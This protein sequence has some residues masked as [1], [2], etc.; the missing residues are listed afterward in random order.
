MLDMLE[1]KPTRPCDEN[2]MTNEET[3]PALRTHAGTCEGELE[4]RKE[5]YKHGLA[6]AKNGDYRIYVP[7]VR[8]NDEPGQNPTDGLTR[9]RLANGH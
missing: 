2:E 8:L 7:Q 5:E 1:S 3:A 4:E 6:R 9:M